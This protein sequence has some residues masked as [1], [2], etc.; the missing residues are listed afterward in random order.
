[1][2]RRVSNRRASLVRAASVSNEAKRAKFVE[3]QKQYKKKWRQEHVRERERVGE[4]VKGIGEKQN[5]EFNV[6][7]VST[8]AALHFCS[9]CVSFMC[10]PYT[11]CGPG[12][13]GLPSKPATSRR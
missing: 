2:V 4:A 3:A 9:C 1:M 7:Q 11:R 12:A 8:L 5:D 13:A 6:A 10:A